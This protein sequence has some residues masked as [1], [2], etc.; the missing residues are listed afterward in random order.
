MDKYKEKIRKLLALSESS[1]EFEAKSALL[2]AKEL[3]AIHKI[4]EIDLKEVKK[5]EVKR[6]TTEYTYTKRGEWW[7]SGLANIIA[8]NYCCRC[9]AVKMHN[10]QKRTIIFIGLEDD[11]DLCAIVF[12]YAIKSIRS[13]AD[14]KLKNDKRY[15]NYSISEKRMALNSYAAGFTLGVKEALDEQKFSNKEKWGLVMIVPSEVDAVVSGFKKDRYTGKNH[16]VDSS[17]HNSGFEEGRRF[18]PNNKLGTVN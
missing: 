8:E 1:N 17:Y 12:E 10:A 4:K 15:L 11:V 7:M 5:K 14:I 13:L 9:G 2:K 16:Y 3:M 18:N 6:I